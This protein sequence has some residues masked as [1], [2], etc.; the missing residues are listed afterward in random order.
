MIPHPSFQEHIGVV[1]GAA[2]VGSDVVGAVVGAAVVGSDVVGASVLQLSICF[3][4]VPLGG[5]A[6]IGDV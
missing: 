4:T 3:V 6:Y 5:S 2:V 1:V